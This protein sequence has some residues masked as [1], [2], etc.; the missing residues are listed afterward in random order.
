MARPVPDRLR[1]QDILSVLQYGTARHLLPPER[2]FGSG[3]SCRRRL[4]R[5]QKAGVTGQ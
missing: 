2:G 1:P 3:Q 4:D 5:W